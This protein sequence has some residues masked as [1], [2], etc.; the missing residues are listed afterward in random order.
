MAVS[1]HALRRAQVFEQNIPPQLRLTFRAFVIGYV[2]S[3][4]P[5]LLSFV[6]TY[7]ARRSKAQD[8]D[9]SYNGIAV[10]MRIF[11]KSLGWQRFPFF[12]AVLAGVSAILVSILERGLS[13]NRHLSARMKSRTASF[14]SAFIAAWLSLK[15]LQS[16]R[17][18]AFVDRVSSAASPTSKEMVLKEVHFAGR[19]IDLT[20]FAFIRASDAVIGRLWARRKARLENTNSWT[21]WSYGFISRHVDSSVFATSCALIMWAWIYVPERLPKA[22]DR[23]LTSAAAIDGRLTKLLRR[24]SWGDF[25]YGQNLGPD[26]LLESMCADYGWP[27]LWSYPTETIPLPCTIVCLIHNR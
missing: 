7:W 3:T 20:L 2:S 21:Y 5:Q 1:T 26:P 8:N 9:D 19:T 24:A 27:K 18:E 15:L 17:S 13:Q 4:F 23:W 6:T 16:K 25:M 10:L 11:R 22:Y 12:C 14:L